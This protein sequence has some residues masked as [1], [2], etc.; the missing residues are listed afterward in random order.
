[1][2][3]PLFVSLLIALCL[4]AVAADDGPHPDM[5]AMDAPPNPHTS[6]KKF[7]RLI[8]LTRRAAR[9]RPRPPAR[10]PARPLP[11]PFSPAPAQPP[12]QTR[13]PATAAT[14]CRRRPRS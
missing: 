8:A 12:K 1:M 6:G 11:R 3:V 4:G 2:R 5:A 7:V 10:P 9:A 14:T 13:L